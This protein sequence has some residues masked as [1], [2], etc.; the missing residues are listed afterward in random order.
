MFLKKLSAF[1]AIS[2]IIV[3]TVGTVFAQG[4]GPANPSHIVDF[5]KIFF[6]SGTTGGGGQSGVT[7]T[8]APASRQPPPTATAVKSFREIF[9]EVGGK[10]GVPPRLLESVLAIEH[11]DYLIN[12]TSEQVS[13]YS[14]PG[15]VIPKCGPNEC[16][17]AGAMQMT[18]GVDNR[19]SSV[20][21]A[22][23]EGLKQC[24]NMWGAYGKSVNTNG[25]YTHPPNPCNLRDNI[26]AAA[27]KIKNDSG[28]S[29]GPWTKEQV[30]RVGLRYYGSCS[31][32]FSFL[33]DMTYCEFLW[34]HYGKE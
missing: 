22:C 10:V 30:F 12:F 29:G 6:P 11:G 13:A 34:W 19:G 18:I 26:Y 32:K 5:L 7:E 14:V 1:I 33:N 27:A 17:A 4:Q 2:F 15:A 3:F 21:A 9:T 31:K 28:N 24:P 20:C 25:G 8:T 23:G 16:S